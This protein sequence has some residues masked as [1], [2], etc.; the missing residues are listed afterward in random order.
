MKVAYDTRAYTRD[1]ALPPRSGL[2]FD[3]PDPAVI[4][5]EPA[6]TLELSGD[7]DVFRPWDGQD[8]PRYGPH[9]AARAE[10]AAAAAKDAGPRDESGRLTRRLV[11]SASQGEVRSILTEAHQNL[12]D[13]LKAAISGGED[14]QKAWAA[15][16]RLNKLIRRGQRKIGDL[17]KEDLL[18][19][20]RRHAEKRQ[21]ELRA[22]QLRQE[23]YRQIEQRKLR[24]KKYLHDAHPSDHEREAPGSGL[25]P[26]ALQAKINALA[27]SLAQLTASPP[28]SLTASVDGTAAGGDAPAE[29]GGAE[30]ASVEP[31]AASGN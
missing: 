28:V 24:E 13:W 22:K 25:S 2:D 20:K 4:P 12:T 11:A 3:E 29:T 1:Y 26:A 15:I 9:G 21:E 18:R 19:I 7:G 17:D 5:E 14:S 31:E 6:A 27:A 16:K 10:K 23:L 8:R 30:T